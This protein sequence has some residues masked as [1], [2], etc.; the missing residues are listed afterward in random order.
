[1]PTKS[2]RELLKNVSYLG[3]GS[4][5]TRTMPALG[6]CGPNP[7]GFQNGIRLFFIGSWLFL[8]DP[9]NP[10][11]SLLAVTRNLPLVSHS[12]PCG[13]W[14]DAGGINGKPSL[15]ANPSNATADGAYPVSVGGKT[16]SSPSVKK[17]FED[18]AQH[19]GFVYVTNPNLDLKFTFTS[20]YLRI[21]RIQQLPTRIVTAD[22]ISGSSIDTQNGSY[23]ASS[24][25][26]LSAAHILDYENGSSLSFNGQQEI[27]SGSQLHNADY[28]F[29][30]VPPS[31][32]LQ[33]HGARM[34][35]SLLGSVTGLKSAAIVIPD[36]DPDRGPYVPCSVDQSELA[37]SSRRHHQSE[38]AQH[39]LI[40]NTA[41]CA[42]GGVGVGGH[43]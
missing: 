14:P 31:G 32:A 43:G 10:G 30:T 3:V 28:H 37:T 42:G 13:V 7:Q 16:N 21:I 1:M 4:L 36:T 11:K 23:P 33:G 35:K 20:K 15:K 2:R 19:Y 34:L 40:N 8:D 26:P 27:A 12:F 5:V 38:G 9:K 25:G 22:I 41:S 6:A 17:L 39:G 29:H 18:A 24:V